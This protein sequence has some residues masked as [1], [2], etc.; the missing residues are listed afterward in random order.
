MIRL[1]TLFS[2]ISAFLLILGQSQVAAQDAKTSED[3]K[4]VQGCKITFRIPD[5]LE[6]M[7]THGK[8]TCALEFQ[9]DRMSLGICYGRFCNAP[10]DLTGRAGLLDYKEEPIEIEGHSAR[11]VTYKGSTSN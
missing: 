5:E 10:E 1:L 8:D 3:W 4:Q 6:R 2:L 9:S 7:E 11:F